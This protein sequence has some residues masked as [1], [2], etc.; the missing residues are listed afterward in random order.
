MIQTEFSLLV[1]PFSYRC[2][3]ACRYCFYRSKEAL[4]GPV[5]KPMSRSILATMTRSYLALPFQHHLIGW[6][7]GE[8]LLAG[9]DFFA[10]AF[11]LQKRESSCSPINVSN[12]IQTNGTLIDDEW[13]QLFAEHDVLVGVS[14]DGTERLHDSLRKTPDGKGSYRNVLRGIEILN[15]H[16]VRRNSLTLV[17]RNNAPFAREIYRHLKSLGMRHQQFIECV[18][19]NTP[20]DG[21]A[22]SISAREWGLF[23]CSLFDEWYDAGDFTC[24]SVRLFDSILNRLLTGIPSLCQMCGSCRNYLV[25]EHDGRVFPCDFHVE[26]NLCAGNVTELSWNELWNSETVREFGLEKGR[27]DSQCRQCRYLPL[28]MGDC[29]NNRSSGRS[30]LCDGWRM[31]YDHTIQRFEE[32]AARLDQPR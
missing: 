2:N 29:P 17:T 32:L 25:V 3:L 7:G 5:T 22:D 21:Q 1:K 15:S 19:S 23:L 16:H 30:M 4:F 24:V 27:I 11:E 20:H 12:T 9:K 8:C 18:P 31:F 14:I 26:P 10:D 28:C 13:A 6:Q